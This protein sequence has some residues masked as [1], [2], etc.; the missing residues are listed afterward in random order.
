MI[1]GSTTVS[2]IGTNK[3]HDFGMTDSGK[4]VMRLI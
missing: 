4:H 1:I 2:R 3:K